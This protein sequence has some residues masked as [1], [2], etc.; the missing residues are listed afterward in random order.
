MYLLFLYLF[1]LNITSINKPLLYKA[2]SYTLTNLKKLLLSMIS[3]LFYYKVSLSKLDFLSN[4]YKIVL[5]LIKL[6]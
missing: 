3:I 1:K 5:N 6:R 2:I 4:S